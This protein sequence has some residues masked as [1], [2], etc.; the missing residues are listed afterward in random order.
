[1]YLLGLFC[2]A[3]GIALAIKSGLGGPPVNTI[4]YAITLISGLDIGIATLI[5][6]AGLIALQILLLKN[7]FKIVNIM[8]LPMCMIFS[9]FVGGMNGLFQQFSI[10]TNILYRLVLTGAGCVFIALG[11]FWYLSAEIISLPSEGIVT[12]LSDKLRISF[13][14]MKI[15]FDCFLS[16]VSALGCF[17]IIGELG[18]VGVG[19]FI[20]GTMVGVIH[21][22][23]CLWYDVI[24]N[25]KEM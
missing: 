25:K 17:I 18:S 2:V 5:F 21:K 14:K 22:G 9:W 20:L 19:T 7:E 24:H 1:M 23:I 16:A 3:T 4:P 15:L 13:S 12:V 6:Q 10:G 8:Q 11:L